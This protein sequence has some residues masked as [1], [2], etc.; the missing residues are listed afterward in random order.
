MS[1][2]LSHPLFL[3]SLVV[4][5]TVLLWA[6]SLLPEFIT[7]LL[8]FTV[9]MAAKIAPPDMIFGGFASSAFWLVFSGFVLGI[10]IRKTGLA[11]RAARALSAKLTDSWLLMVS[12][13]VL[14]SY[15]LAFVMPS[16]MGR[17]ALL[18]PIVAAMA[19]RAGIADG[20]RAWYGLALA[21][22]FGTFQLS[23]TILPANVPNLVMSGAAEGSYGIHLN[24]VPYLLLHTP[25]LAWLKGAV[26]IALICWLFPGAPCTPREAEAS[27]PMSRN[28]KRLAWMLTVVLTMWVTE[29]WH[30]IGPAWTGLAA[31]VVTML[32]RIGFISGDEFASG[33]NIRAC[34]YVAGIL[35]LALT[36]TQ[37]GIGNAVGETL[38]HV[39][40]LDTQK[41]FTSFLALTGITTALNFIMTANGVPA[42]YTTLAESFAAATGFPL[43]SVIM[44]QVLG[45][46]T[47]ILPY[48]AS[49]IVVAMALGKVPAK[50]GML[51]CLALA[52][53][54]YLV[55][56]PLDYAWF[57]VLGKL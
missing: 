2:W 45:Y 54:T 57:R 22:G 5:I 51:L 42:L 38:L 37:T 10:A 27:A 43:L 55:L 50:A 16:N 40:P 14:L 21:V 24:Y 6:T 49:P 44:I 34:I 32:P 19:K 9:A 56:L 1:L 47:P 30:G 35:G 13:V 17:I 11:D 36:V 28:E 26:L 18:M 8:F 15:A 7:A 41:P 4:G 25:I 39:M 53:V 29:S 48:Q 20:T 31:A 52:A 12:S 23:A 33:I 3:P 46:S